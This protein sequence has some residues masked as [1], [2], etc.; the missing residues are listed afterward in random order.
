MIFGADTKVVQWCWVKVCS[1]LVPGSSHTYN[2]SVA[3]FA[4]YTFAPPILVT[5]L[6]AGSVLVRFVLTLCLCLPHLLTLIRSAIL[7]SFLLNE[8]LGHLG[9]MG[10]ALSMLGSLII[11]LHAPEDKDV[12][13][14]DEI[15]EY[16][17]H[18]GA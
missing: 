2:I 13:S 6:G 9:R 12:Q 15:L 10:C 5:P 4:A 8:H 11:V 1:S 18:P 14:V 7:A 3:N 16:A 17:M